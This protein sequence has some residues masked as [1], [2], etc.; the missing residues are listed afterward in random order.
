[1][2]PFADGADPEALP[3][4]AGRFRF[5]PDSSSAAAAGAASRSHTA[6]NEEA[7]LAVIAATSDPVVQTFLDDSSGEY[8]VGI[9]RRGRT[10]HRDSR[11]RV[12]TGSSWFAETVDDAEVIAY[13]EAVAGGP[14]AAAPTSRCARPEQG[15]RLLEVKRITPR[16]RTPCSGLAHLDV[17]AAAQR[18]RPGDRLGVG[19]H[20]GVVHGLREPRGSRA[21]Q[22]GGG[23]RSR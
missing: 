14:P 21:A 4:L 6:R 12:V 3:A 9:L 5:S 15:V 19:D 16:S 18:R 2:A 10:G 20:F 17:G 8:T 11:S 1:M 13:A 7:L 22:P 23:T